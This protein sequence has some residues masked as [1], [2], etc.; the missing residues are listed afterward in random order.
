MPQHIISPKTYF[1]VCV[2]LLALTAVTVGASFLELGPLHTVVALAIAV[3]KAVLIILYFM[4]MRYSSGLTRLVLLAGLL[5]LGILIV[6]TLDDYMTR[7]WLGV[8]G[9]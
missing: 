1:A 5:W 4:H 9:K 2:A 3:A 8:P 7:S 6:G